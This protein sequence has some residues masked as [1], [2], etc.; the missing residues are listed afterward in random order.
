MSNLKKGQLRGEK[1]PRKFADFRISIGKGKIF[2]F[3]FLLEKSEHILL[4]HVFEKN[5]HVVCK[6]LILMAESETNI[7]ISSNKQY[8]HMLSSLFSSFVN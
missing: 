5:I 3:S 6:F 1:A 2:L 4:K 8:Y 7:C